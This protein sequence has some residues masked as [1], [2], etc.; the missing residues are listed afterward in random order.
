MTDTLMRWFVP[1]PEPIPLPAT[2]ID[3]A[4]FADAR[5]VPG[6]VLSLHPR[7]GKR[8]STTAEDYVSALVIGAG[9]PGVGTATNSALQDMPPSDATVVEI[10]AEFT[11]PTDNAAIS[12]V[13]EAGLDMIQ[14]LQRAYYIAT[15]DA[16]QLV[17]LEGLPGMLPWAENIPTNPHD[18]LQIG[19]YLTHTSAMRRDVIPSSL[20]DAQLNAMRA[21]LQGGGGPFAPVGDLRREAQA[22]LYLRGDYRGASLASATCAEVLLDT[23]LLHMLWAEGVSAAG[24]ADLITNTPFATRVKTEF[25]IRLGGDWDVNGA[26]PIGNWHRDTAQLR[27]RVVHGGY[28]PTRE[29]AVSSLAATAKLERYI[30]DQ[31]T[32][33]GDLKKHF[34]TAFA[35]VGVPGLQS[36]NVL[37]KPIQQLVDALPI[38]PYQA[39]TTWRATL[40]Q[41]I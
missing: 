29:Q 13:F 39:F 8:R 38:H 40:A 35:F 16:I 20:H 9:S 31:L 15:Q 41:H 3:S 10:R 1:L 36:R 30:G 21:V 18:P 37:S 14:L 4:V 22:A 32:K 33:P 12:D 17:T 25:H 28:R 26:G 6:V 11:I 34:Q 27:H 5:D 23:T 2:P 24:G 7:Q 19:A